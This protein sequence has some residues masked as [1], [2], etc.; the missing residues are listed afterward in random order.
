MKINRNFG[1]SSFL[2]ILSAFLL[3]GIIPVDKNEII[4]SPESGLMTEAIRS[5]IDQCAAKGGGTV[6]LSKGVFHSG[7]IVLKPNV[8]LLLDSG[9]TLRGS[10]RYSDYR[11]D[12]FIYGKDLTN[13]AIM[14]KGT[15]DG[16]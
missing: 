7:T 13:I 9:A 12:A 5:A 2:F 14:G 8:T 1:I 11:N 3:S 6:R 15:I 10:D 4:L 16:G